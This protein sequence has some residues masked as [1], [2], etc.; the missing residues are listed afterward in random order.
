MFGR[1]EGGVER[2]FTFTEQHIDILV[3]RWS[4]IV[5]REGLNA[6]S[7]PTAGTVMALDLC[8]SDANKP[9][10]LENT[11]FLPYAVVKNKK[12]KPPSCVESSSGD[13]ICSDG[14]ACAGC[15]SARP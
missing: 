13:L 1:D 2:H 4:G 5:R 14:H 9:M 6:N 10:L 12:M 8:I 3:T 15:T 7:K 11:K